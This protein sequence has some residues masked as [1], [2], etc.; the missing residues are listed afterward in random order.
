MNEEPPEQNDVSRGDPSDH[1]PAKESDFIE[2]TPTERIEAT[3]DGL[4]AFNSVL[5]QIAK[6][7]GIITL[8]LFLIFLLF[9]AWQVAQW[10][11]MTI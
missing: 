2:I 9:M 11:M 8:I 6:T 4:S 7:F 10:G 3:A 1:L 5:W